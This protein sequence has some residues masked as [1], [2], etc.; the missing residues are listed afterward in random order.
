M[1]HVVTFQDYIGL[2]STDDPL[3]GKKVPPTITSIDKGDSAVSNHYYFFKD[4][5]ALQ[6][7]VADKFGPTVVLT[8]TSTLTKKSTETITISLVRQL[9]RKENIIA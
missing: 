3:I 2:P 7:I 5:A 9:S 4:I 8:N 6:E 1:E